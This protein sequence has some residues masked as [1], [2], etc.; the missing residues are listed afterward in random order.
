MEIAEQWR[1]R[2]T[3]D[4]ISATCR[5]SADLQIIRSQASNFYVPHS[6]P[7]RITVNARCIDGIDGPSLTPSR[8]FEGRHWEEAQRKRIAEGGHAAPAGWNG[9]G[10]GNCR[11]NQVRT[12][13]T[14]GGR[15]IRT[16]GPP[17]TVSSVVT[18]CPTLGCE[19]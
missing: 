8:F 2:R 11:Q 1:H 16:L 19:G 7:D 9:A 13:L 4:H 15:R 6:Q 10:Y 3:P 14:A 18:S 12:R 17:A 5:I